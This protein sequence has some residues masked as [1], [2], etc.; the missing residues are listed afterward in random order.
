[1]QASEARAEGEIR[2]DPRDLSADSVRDLASEMTLTSDLH[3]ML[4]NMHVDP[5]TFVLYA[6]T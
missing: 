1:M 4:T 2:E 6:D 5:H 3:T